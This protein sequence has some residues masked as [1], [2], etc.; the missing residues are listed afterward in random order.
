MVTD[1]IEAKLNTENNASRE[2]ELM[3]KLMT[4]YYDLKA[5][6]QQSQATQTSSSSAVSMEKKN[7]PGETQ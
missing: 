2:V 5:V 3:H 4:L 7:S 1:F 6:N